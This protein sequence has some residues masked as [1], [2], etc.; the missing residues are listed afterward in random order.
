MCFSPAA[1]RSASDAMVGGLRWNAAAWHPDVQPEPPA[2]A[3]ACYAR[4][5]APTGA[6]GSR[7]PAPRWQRIRSHTP[8]VMRGA[9]PATPTSTVAAGVAVGVA[10]HPARG[11]GPP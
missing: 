5:D 3:R 4:T 9:G 11:R 6:A 1:L 8:L 2:A 10:A 7:E